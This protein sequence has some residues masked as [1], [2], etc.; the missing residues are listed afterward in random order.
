MPTTRLCTSDVHAHPPDALSASKRTL[1]PPADLALTPHYSMRRPYAT[2]MAS[3]AF[4]FGTG[5][6]LAQQ[7]I[8]KRGADHDVGIGPLSL[9]ER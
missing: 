8:E 2:G 5:D 9:A 4:L 6:V 3:A 7:G 1:L